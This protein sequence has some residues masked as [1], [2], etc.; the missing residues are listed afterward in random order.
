MQ[1][2]KFRSPVQEIW[3]LIPRPVEWR[4]CR[5]RLATAATFLRLGVSG[6][7]HTT[8]RWRIPKQACYTSVTLSK[9]SSSSFNPVFPHVRRWPDS[10]HSFSN[11]SHSLSPSRAIC[12]FLHPQSNLLYILLDLFL[13]CLLRPCLQKQEDKFV[14]GKCNLPVMVAQSSERAAN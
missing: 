5:Q 10:P 4:Y 7:L 2:W 9:T 6:H 11:R 13:P 14:V 1:V 3:G 12:S 8:L